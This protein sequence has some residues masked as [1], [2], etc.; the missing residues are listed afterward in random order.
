MLLE[1]L[2]LAGEVPQDS[3]QQ[4]ARSPL[5]AL[6]V[7]LAIA[8]VLALRHVSVGSWLLVAGAVGNLASWVGDGMVPDYLTLAIG[9]FWVAFNLADMSILAGM[10]AMIAA[11]AIRIETHL[12]PGAAVH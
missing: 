7:V 10:L 5:W 4:H 6:V 1:H 8:L 12:R 2:A 11:S 9:N 3:W